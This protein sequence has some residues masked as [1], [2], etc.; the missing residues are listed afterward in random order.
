MDQCEPA[1][2]DLTLEGRWSTFGKRCALTG[3]KR[4]KEREKSLKAWY[5]SIAATGTAS[6]I[7]LPNAPQ[8]SRPT[9]RGKK[10]RKGLATAT[11][12]LRERQPPVMRGASNS[13]SAEGAKSEERQK[14]RILPCLPTLRSI[15][16]MCKRADEKL[17]N[18]RNEF[19]SGWA[20]GIAQLSAT[21]GMRRTSA[22]NGV[23]IMRI[24]KR[25]TESVEEEENNYAPGE[26]MH[27]LEDVDASVTEAFGI[28]NW[29]KG[30]S[31]YDAPVLCFMGLNTR[32]SDHPRD[33]PHRKGSIF[34]SYN[35]S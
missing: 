2:G 22:Q 21:R 10:G 28:L 6:S 31:C 23:R 19:E 9:T 32:L 7:S 11:I 5:D 33:C 34:M 3:V 29:E 18:M 27:D 30:S 14:I 8:P 24:K 16:V 17:E 13:T 15:S 26:G 1:T 12:S 4:A 25:A 35:T 20:E